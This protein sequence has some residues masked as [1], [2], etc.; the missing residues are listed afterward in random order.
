MYEKWFILYSLFLLDPPGKY[1]WETSGY[2]PLDTSPSFYAIFVQP[3]MNN[4]NYTG[5]VEITIHTTAAKHNLWLHANNVNFT[6]TV[7]LALPSKTAVPIKTTIMYYP[8]S[9][10]VI[11]FVNDLPA[12]D[13]LLQLVYYGTIRDTDLGG[14]YFYSYNDSDHVDR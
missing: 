10:I 14:E 5:S 3:N 1:P 6:S 11:E 2:L 13:Y 8:H 7:V 9:F 4:G 12:G